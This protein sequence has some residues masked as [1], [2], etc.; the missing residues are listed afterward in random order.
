MNQIKSN[1]VKTILVIITGLLVVYLFAKL[2]VLLNIILALG[3]IGVFSPYLSKKVE[4]LWFKI[5][6]FLSL[7]IPNIILGLVFYFFL[8]PIALLSR[9][10][11]K[12]PLFLKNSSNSIYKEVNKSFKKDS[13]KNT[14]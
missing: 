9:I 13:F 11:S 5:A 4:F 14:W 2:D 3:I 10:S 12:D 7:I 8:F 6:Y 1:P